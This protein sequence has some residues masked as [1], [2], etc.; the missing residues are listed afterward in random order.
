M[1]DDAPKI[2]QYSLVQVKADAFDDSPTRAIFRD[3]PLAHSYFVF[4]GEIPNMPGHCVVAQHGGAGM[5][6]S[7]FETSNFEVVP[8]KET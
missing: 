1:S 7:G 2:E 8:T 6:I 5:V 4:L 3:H